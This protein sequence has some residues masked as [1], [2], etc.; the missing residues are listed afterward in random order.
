MGRFR[1]KSDVNK[2]D[3]YLDYKRLLFNNIIILR[4]YI[5]ELEEHI[6]EKWNTLSKNKHDIKKYLNIIVSLMRVMLS[7]I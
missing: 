5:K 3:Y 4:D 7:I 1:I 6:E 2:K